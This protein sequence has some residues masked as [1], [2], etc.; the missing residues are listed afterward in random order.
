MISM[1]PCQG[2]I[3]TYFSSNLGEL[4]DYC[5]M[6]EFSSYKSNLTN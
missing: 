3:I 1:T 6:V 2:Q 5:P 4:I